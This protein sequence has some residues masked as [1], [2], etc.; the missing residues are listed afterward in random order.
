MLLNI[1][2]KQV[3]IQINQYSVKLILHL[4]REKIISAI[5]I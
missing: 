4:M 5:S 3:K 1:V 2:I